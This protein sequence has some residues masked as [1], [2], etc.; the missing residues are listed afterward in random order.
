M[1]ILVPDN[2]SPRTWIMFT[3][4]ETLKEY[5]EDFTEGFIGTMLVRPDA[6]LPVSRHQMYLETPFY[7]Q[8]VSLPFVAG[9]FLHNLL[10]P[11]IYSVYDY[12]VYRVDTSVV[13]LFKED[14]AKQFIAQL[15]GDYK[16]VQRSLPFQPVWLKQTRNYKKLR[17]HYESSK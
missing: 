2:I 9:H 6:P 3:L 17:G 15:M 10:S 14:Y 13:S 4:K 5:M 1:H 8:S 16:M 7:V 12:K 11:Q